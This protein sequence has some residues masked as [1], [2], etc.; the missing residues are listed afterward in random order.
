MRLKIGV[1]SR[2]RRQVLLLV[3]LL[4][5]VTVGRVRVCRQGERADTVSVHD[6]RGIAQEGKRKF[7]VAADRLAG[8]AAT[9]NEQ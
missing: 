1:C 3:G 4:V 7:W 2:E 5:G 8:S 9:H 6:E